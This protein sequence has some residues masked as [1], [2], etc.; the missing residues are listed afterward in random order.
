M[1]SWLINRGGREGTTEKSQADF[2]QGGRQDCVVSRFEAV[3]AIAKFH[4]LSRNIMRLFA[5]RPPRAT[6]GDCTT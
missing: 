6:S 4:S 3:L 1:F 2:K 5:K